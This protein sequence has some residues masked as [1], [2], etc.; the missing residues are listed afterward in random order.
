LLK[1]LKTI[2]EKERA[3]LIRQ[4]MGIVPIRQGLRAEEWLQ[5]RIHLYYFVA[6][7]VLCIAGVVVVTIAMTK[8]GSAKDVKAGFQSL[9]Q[10]RQGVE[11]DK[12][13]Q[14]EYATIGVQRAF[15]ESRLGP[16]KLES[17]GD[18]LAQATYEFPQY[19]LQIVYDSGN[20][21]VQFSVTSIDPSFRPQIPYWPHGTLK[22]GEFT[23]SQIFDAVPYYFNFSAKKWIYIETTGGGISATGFNRIDFSYT[24]SGGYCSAREQ[25]TDAAEALLAATDEARNK[26]L[27]PKLAAKLNAYRSS[28]C[29][30]SFTV[31]SDAVAE[32]ESGADKDL[33]LPS[34]EDI[35]TGW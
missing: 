35:I 19:F 21:I 10:K 23:F 11:L 34:V 4:E 3:N 26:N 24:G 33:M 30:D 1:N 27:S 16:P 2:P 6:F 32:L 31:S 14:W 18:L 17:K 12:K 20:R 15:I 22:L 8:Q 28:V 29:P 9:D 25:P 13:D 7:I 5:S